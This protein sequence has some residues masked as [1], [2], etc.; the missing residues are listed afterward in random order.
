MNYRMIKYTLGWLLI[1]E[2]AFMLLPLI[3]GA[4]YKEKEIL[5]FLIS[6]A[7]CSAIGGLMIIRKPQNTTLYS[8][9]GIVIAALGWVIMSAFGALPFYISGSIPEYIDALFETVS[10]FTTTGSSIL[11][12]IEFLPNGEPMPRS[13]LIWRSFTHWVGGMGVLVFLMAFLPL[14]GA[15]NLHIMKA[16]SPGPSVSKLVPRVRTSAL[17][18]YTIYFVLTIAMAI[19]LLCGGLPLFDS[20][21]TAFGT[22]GTGGFGVKNDSLAGFSSYLQ[23]VTTVFMLIFSINFT[24]YYLLTKRKFKEAINTEIRCFFIIVA[25]AIT[26]I[27]INTYPFYAGRDNQLFETIKH[28]AFTVASLISTSGFVT[29]NFDV[30]PIFSKVILL[31]LMF[32]G[33]C[34]GSTGGGI[35]VSRIILFFKSVAR[36]FRYMLHP[37]QVRKIAIDG[38]P[39]DDQVARSVAVYLC[40]YVIVFF[41]SLLLISLDPACNSF[42]TAFSSVTTTLNNIGPGLDLVGPTSNFASLSNFSKIVLSFNM[43][44]GRLELFPILLLFSP[45]TWK[46]N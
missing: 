43:L 21:C 7:I 45:S 33:A 25:V 23:I 13:I 5:D 6:M 17:I 26:L 46:K 28:S 37:K 8:R 29:E 42:T 32:I 27:S 30:W 24:S 9:E 11:T 18:L 16:E 10:G 4:I 15:N 41:S 44:A 1:F 35:K 2:T 34:A 19:L 12:N 36:E 40:C 20:I 22:A 31:L 14:S 3:T 38:K 39:I